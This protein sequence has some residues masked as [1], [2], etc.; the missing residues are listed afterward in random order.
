MIRGV[1]ILF[2]LNGVQIA[3]ASDC[4]IDFSVDFLEA[5]QPNSG[6]YEN[7]IPDKINVNINISGTL[8]FAQREDIYSHLDSFT[9]V[10]YSYHTAVAADG[11]F[12]GSCWV[13]TWGE[14]SPSTS[15]ARYNASF[16]G[17]GFPVFTP[18]TPDN[19]EDELDIILQD[20]GNVDLQLG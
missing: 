17:D 18:E 20:H 1:N 8:T 15:F 13:R 12:E 2:T 3:C 5:R 6:K 10:T 7:F 4:D 9:K 19:W 14:S 11:K 16:L